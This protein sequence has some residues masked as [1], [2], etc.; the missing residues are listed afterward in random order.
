MENSMLISVTNPLA[1]GFLQ[2]MKLVNPYK[3]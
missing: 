2:Q 1:M 3:K